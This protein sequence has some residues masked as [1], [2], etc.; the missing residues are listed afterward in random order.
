M[1][2]LDGKELAKIKEE[3]LKEK[4]N[5][6]P[7]KLTLAVILLSNDDASLSYLKGRQKLCER[8]NVNLEV[9]TFDEYQILDS[10]EYTYRTVLSSTGTTHYDKY[11]APE[12]YK[13]LKIPF[14]SNNFEGK[15]MID[16]SIK[17]GTINYIDNKNKRSVV[18]F[19][20]PFGR[21]YYGKYLYT[22]VPAEMEEAKSIEIHYTI[23]DQ[24]YVYKL[25]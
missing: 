14:G 13:I 17:Y 15:D 24:K 12:G 20:N 23:R 16:F 3:S 2:K 19:K 7:R 5:T 1:I 21:V 9:I 18:K 8:M 6:L 22:R 11:T 10:T 25:R 4:L